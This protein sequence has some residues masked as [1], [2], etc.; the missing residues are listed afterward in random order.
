MALLLQLSVPCQFITKVKFLC[1][2]KL[3]SKMALLGRPLNSSNLTLAT[4]SQGGFFDYC[5][6]LQNQIAK[7]SHK[8]LLFYFQLQSG[9]ASQTAPQIVCPNFSSSSHGR[10]PGLTSPIPP[11]SLLSRKPKHKCKVSERDILTILYRS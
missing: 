9:E 7:K 4:L 11:V 5:Y 1:F 2:G 10:R 6:R 3:S 8:G